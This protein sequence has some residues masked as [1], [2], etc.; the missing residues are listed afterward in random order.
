MVRVASLKA[1]ASSRR[2][3]PWLGLARTSRGAN[4]LGAAS[5]SAHWL[6]LAGN[7]GRLVD[8][9]PRPYRSPAA[10]CS[11]LG[12]LRQL[13]SKDPT[14]LGARGA[15][16]FQ[17]HSAYGNARL[18]GGASSHPIGEGNTN[19]EE[20]N[21]IRAGTAGSGSPPRPAPFGSPGTRSSIHRV[22]PG[23]G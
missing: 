13:V 12:L 1:Q 5:T 21:G 9:G 6:A 3:A 22:E 15:A 10:P 17:T 20:K 18:A 19:I 11:V 8:F 2:L 23:T 16:A 7:Q 14:P 4:P